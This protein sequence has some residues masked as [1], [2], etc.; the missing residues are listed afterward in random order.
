MVAFLTLDSV[1][2]ATPDGRPLFGGLTLAIGRE[3]TGFV[4][5]NGCGKSTLLRVIAGDIQPAA[6]SVQRAGSIGMLSQM[7]DDSLTVAEAL[8]VANGLARLRRLEQGEGLFDDAIEVDWT[9]ESKLDAALSEVGLPALPQDCRVA[10]LSGGEKTRLALARLLID[11]P[12]V[13]LLDEPTNNLD[14]DGRRAIVELLKRWRGGVVVASHDRAL[15]SHV[16][17]IVELNATGE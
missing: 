13:M 15:L 17:R 11:A 3:R 10:S 4:G 1:S 2:L 5:R 8:G 16:D 12:D 7:A 6:G 14:A 9:L